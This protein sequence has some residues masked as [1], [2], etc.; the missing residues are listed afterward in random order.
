MTRQGTGR[1]EIK[2]L[3]IKNCK[4]TVIRKIVKYYEKPLIKDVFT[5]EIF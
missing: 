2:P 5:D 4:E 3:M 1:Q